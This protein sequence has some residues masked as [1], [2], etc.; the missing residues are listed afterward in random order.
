[1]NFNNIFENFN[2]FDFINFNVITCGITYLLIFLLV[3]IILSSILIY[4]IIILEKLINKR[5]DKI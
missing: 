5:G 1:M 2:N 3:L 4:I